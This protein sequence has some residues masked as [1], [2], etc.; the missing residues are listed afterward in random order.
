VR[1]GEF[2]ALYQAIS[3]A[4]AQGLVASVHGVYRGGL[5]VHLSMVA[6]GG[7]LGMQVDLRKIPAEAVRRN[8][9][10]LFSESAGRFIVTVAPH[11][12]AEFE[13]A[14]PALPFAC[15]GT[16]MD[17]AHLKVE[18]LQGD[19]AI[20]LPVSELKAAWKSPFGQLI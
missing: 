14:F 20:S 8:D 2:G 15:I 12:K 6:M 7:G 10:L 13:A 4:V 16:V 18:G 1:S 5:G 9:T 17:D 19:T 11:R 3:E